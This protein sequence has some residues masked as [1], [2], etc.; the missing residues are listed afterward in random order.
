MLLISGLDFD[1][2][3]LKLFRTKFVAVVV[4]LYRDDVT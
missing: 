3:I 4:R 1:V 2:E